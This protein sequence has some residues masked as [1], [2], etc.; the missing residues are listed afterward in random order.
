MLFALGLSRGE[1]P[2]LWNVAQPKMCAVS[3]EYI[4]AGA[5]I[6]LTN[7]FGGNRFAWMHQSR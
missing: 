4:E 2:E 5:Q 7:S 1:S 3:T 6:V